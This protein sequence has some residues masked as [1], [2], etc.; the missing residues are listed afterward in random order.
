MRHFF[1]YGA[2]IYHIGKNAAFDYLRG[3]AVERNYRSHLKPEPRISQIE[4]YYFAS[5]IESHVRMLVRKMPR[6]RYNVF[7]MSRRD[8]LNYH[9]I[10]HRLNISH[11]TVANHLHL[12]LCEIKHEL[13]E[14]YA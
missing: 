12:A 8:G 2:Y 7:L 10:A 6:Q 4:A 3:Y 5:E 14:I 11:K 1:R 9:E 13:D